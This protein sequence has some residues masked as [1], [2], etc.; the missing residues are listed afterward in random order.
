MVCLETMCMATLHKGDND[1]IIII[2]VII[3][4][5]Q[6]KD[7]ILHKHTHTHTRARV[8]AYAV[9]FEL[10]IANKKLLFVAAVPL[11]YQ[12]R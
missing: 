7:V 10:V 5:M 8:C 3:I 6:P 12:K 1:I 4:I 11:S 9:S 2:I